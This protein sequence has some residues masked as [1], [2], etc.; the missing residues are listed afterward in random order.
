MNILVIGNGFDLAH[1]LNTEYKDFLEIINLYT[2]MLYVNRNTQFDVYMKNIIGK[3]IHPKFKE[4]LTDWIT[5]K[6][7]TD[8]TKIF[9]DI[10]KE[11]FWLLYF[12]MLL[13]DELRYKNGWI[14][15]EVEIKTVIKK[16]SDII[17][18][19]GMY[20]TDGN[21]GQI[22]DAAIINAISTRG[23]K[24][25]NNY[26]EIIDLMNDDLV[27]MIRC[28]EIYLDKFVNECIYEGRVNVISPDIMNSKIDK[29]LSF[30][31]T[32][33][34]DLLYDTEGIIE[35][36]YIHGK[37][38]IS[39]TKENNNMVLGIDEFL[40]D[41][42]KNSDTKFIA[43]KKFYQRIYKETG[44]K[45]KDWIET[46]ID[47]NYQYMK[48]IA[49]YEK[50]LTKSD[51]LDFQRIMAGKRIGKLKSNPIRHNLYIFGHSLDITDKDVLQELI[52]TEN[53]YTTIYYHNKEA[54][55]KQ[56]ANLV[57]IIGQDE[58]IKRTSGSEKTI[59][60]KKQ[61]DM[62]KKNDV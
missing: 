58:L 27:S 57:K 24:G 5:N 43:F 46:M 12:N 59:D 13:E 55:G 30:N 61:Q 23:I 35:Y 56:I 42:R 36:D 8:E 32:K 53:V 19:N 21:I 40:P 60:F 50:E 3:K 26:Q 51:R 1:G 15:F 11:N 9:V 44:C 14:D 29:I 7:I 22:G 39:N 4:Y 52:M 41:E 20:I 6:E 10:K 33:T 31:Y 28:L 34:F 16:I 25:I 2:N 38:D 37:A 45:Y 62:I 47:I 54:M 17:D 18:K 48:N 49:F